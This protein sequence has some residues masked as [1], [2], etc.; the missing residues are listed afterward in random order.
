MKKDITNTTTNTTLT[1][2]AILRDGMSAFER[3][4]K[5]VFDVLVA[6]VCLV[7]FSPLFLI[8]CIAVKLEDGGPI[9]YKQERIGKNG[10]PF[11]ILKFRSMCVDAEEDGPQL[12]VPTIKIEDP[13]TTKI[14]AFIRA[15]HLDEL[16]QML[17]V[18][19]G[20]MSL[21]GP[22]PERKFFIEKIMEIDDRYPALYQIRPGVTSY[23]TIY[24]GYTDTIEKMVKRLVYDL[25]YLQK[26]SLWVDIKLL[27][28]T[29]ARILFGKKF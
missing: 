9:L 8:I 14:G 10:K 22:R 15:H 28:L 5:R 26:R 6:V 16:P 11:N 18:L 25:E 2:E 12:S 3:G 4:I 27:Y 17:N 23:A 19:K 21:V 24:N 7:V 13:R 29:F 1:Q 20:D